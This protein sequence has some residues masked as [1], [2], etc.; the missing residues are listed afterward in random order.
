MERSK[1]AGAPYSPV[2]N[3]VKTAI[4]RERGGSVARAFAR[5]KPE[6]D[7]DEIRWGVLSTADIGLHTVIP[8]IQQA[9]NCTV[10]SIASR[11][12][13]TRSRQ[14]YLPTPC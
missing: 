8:A 7:M 14:S 5:R 9:T 3:G 4:P 10:V 6:V 1:G 11:D 13:G 12:A 2:E